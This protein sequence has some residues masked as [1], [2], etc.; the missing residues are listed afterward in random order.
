MSALFDTSAC[1]VVSFVILNQSI[2]LD[3]L[4]LSLTRHKVLNSLLNRSL[5]N[6]VD[7]VPDYT[8][9]V[10]YSDDRRAVCY[11]FSFTTLDSVSLGFVLFRRRGFTR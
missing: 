2:L 1:R 7:S 11:L 9:I 3:S 8:Y 4:S 5:I 6:R 10:R